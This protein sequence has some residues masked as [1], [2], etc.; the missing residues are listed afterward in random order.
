MDTVSDR[1]LIQS[2]G[3]RR[4]RPLR[5]GRAALIAELLPRLEIQAP[6]PGA[7]L[8]PGGLFARP[9]GAV[10]LEVGF[11]GG[12]H[13]AAQAERH[14]DIGFIG[15][16]PYVNGIA[17][18]LARAHDAGLDNLRI[19]PNDVRPLLAALAPC[20]I[21][22]VFVLFP[23]PWPKAR[24]HKRRLVAPPFLDAL[25]RVMAPAAELRLATDDADYAEWMRD[26]LAAHSA[27][28]ADR[29]SVVHAPPA[30]W[31][32]TRYEAKALAEGRISAYL[33]VARRG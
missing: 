20:S 12:E 19:W 22:R 28:G 18:L 16:E 25:A 21:A 30:D 23:D 26:A 29:L 33:A 5:R 14:R 17:G 7:T 27:F 4:G 8:D 10:W 9:V 3:R 6:A 31:I 13:L 32:P 1:R 2:Y 15:G 11:G 24:H